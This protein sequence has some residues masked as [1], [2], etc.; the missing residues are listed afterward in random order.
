MSRKP[1][2]AFGLPACSMRPDTRV[3]WVYAP[4]L[5]ALRPTRSGPRH[6]V[7]TTGGGHRPPAPAATG[8]APACLVGPTRL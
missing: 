5:A 7:H 4:A 8:S 2:Q 3:E 1:P 6:G